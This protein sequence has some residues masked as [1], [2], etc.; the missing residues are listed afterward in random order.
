MSRKQRKQNIEHN[1]NDRWLVSYA[2]FITL[3]FAFFVVMYAVSSVNEGK[4]RV[5]SESLTNA[6]S[7]H[8][9]ALEPIQI[10][11]V[12]KSG[13]PKDYKL[14]KRPV[15][16]DRSDIPRPVIKPRS[17]E[18]KDAGDKPLKIL[19]DAMRTSV[20][21]LTD[22]GLIKVKSNEYGVEIEISTSVLFNSGRTR[23][24][25]QAIPILENLARV[26]KPFPHDVNVQ[27][28]TDNI[29]IQSNIYPSNWELS[30]AR[31]AS[32]VQLFARL[33]IQSSRLSATGFGEF[34]PLADNTTEK[35]RQ[36]NR[37]VVIFIPVFRDKARVLDAIDRLG[38]R[39]DKGITFD[40][41]AG[42]DA[43]EGFRS[44]F[45]KSVPG[46]VDSPV[47]ESRFSNP[48]SP[49]STRK[50]VKQKTVRS[51]PTSSDQSVRN[52]IAGDKKIKSAKPDIAGQPA[53]TTP[54]PARRQP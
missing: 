20:A 10:G 23:L 26:L 9:R 39:M 21:E 34:R 28:Y 2:D 1:N 41:P 24:S 54:V 3:L 33:G 40:R 17:G 22:K 6:F 36:Q 25:K 15:V 11:Q 49:L 44:N 31:A 38:K 16:V 27:G 37:R 19:F 48:V 46:M 35:G 4:Y 43:R 30:A 12:V 51:S 52:S 18:V 7:V 47:G 32:V 14:I 29:P 50:E 5:L 8:A 42:R 45:K 13:D 53:G